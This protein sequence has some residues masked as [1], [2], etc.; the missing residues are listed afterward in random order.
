MCTA[1]E[2]NSLAALSAIV[3]YVLLLFEELASLRDYPSEPS[4]ASTMPKHD[5]PLY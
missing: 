3:A 5:L 2:S 1:R 4:F